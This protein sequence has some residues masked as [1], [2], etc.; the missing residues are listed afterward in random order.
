MVTQDCPGC[1]GWL[2]MEVVQSKMQLK[3]AE[4]WKQDQKMDPGPDGRKSR[5]REREPEGSK[6]EGWKSETVNLNGEPELNIKKFPKSPVRDLIHSFEQIAK[7]NLNGSKPQQVSQVSQRVS[8]SGITKKTHNMYLKPEC[9]NRPTDEHTDRP[10]VKP[11]RNEDKPVNQNIPVG[12]NQ[13]LPPTKVWTRLKSGLFGWKT[14][15]RA[16]TLRTSGPAT[17]ATVP[18]IQPT[19][20]NRNSETR[21]TLPP[22]LIFFWGGERWETN[23]FTKLRKYSNKGIVFWR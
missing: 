1:P 12:V 17:V 3:I 14:V 16:R 11:G 4:G 8:Q 15:A 13:K 20:V 19:Q 7:K 23:H 9:S 22:K 21:Q 18:V 6:P 10:T 5:K 2:C